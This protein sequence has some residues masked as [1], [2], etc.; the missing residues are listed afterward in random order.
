[1]NAPTLSP[2]TGQILNIAAYKFVELTDLDAMRSELKAVTDS[3]GLKGTILLSPE[4]INLFLAGK[5]P[6]VGRFLD[7]L[8]SWPQFADIETKDSYSDD[9]PFRRML[10][11]LKKEI[12]AFGVDGI[13]PA[14]RTSPKLPAKELKAWLDAGKKVRLLD[15][16][17][18]YEFDLGTFR[19]AEKL[20]LD[21]FRDFPEA[22]SQLPDDAKNEPLVM[23]CTGGIRCEKAGPLMEQAGF[24]EVYQLEG[25]ILKYFEECGDAHYDGDC[26]VFDNR[27]A[28]NANLEPTGDILCFACQAVL[29]GDDIANPHYKMGSHCPHCY[30]S[31]QLVR[32]RYLAERQ[33]AI[34]DLAQSQPGSSPYQNLR[35]IFVPRKS[36]GQPLIDFLCQRNP[37]IAREQWSAWIDAGEIKHVSSNWKHRS[38]ATADQIVR[39]GECFEQE[40]PGTIEPEIA[41]EIKL[42][43]EDDDLLVVS[44][45]A[46]LP[47]HPSGRFNRNTLTW[48]LGSVYGNDKLR[49]AHRLDANTSGVVLLCR[50]QRAAKLI[51]QQFVAGS[52]RK[53]YL[54]RVHGHPEWDSHNCEAKISIEPGPSGTRTIDEVGGWDARTEISVLRREDDGTTL[55]EVTPKTGRTNQIRIHLWHLGHSIVGDPLY[56]PDRATAGVA[57]DQVEQTAGTL[58]VSAQ[59]MCL[60]SLQL[61]IVHPTS[62]EAIEFVAPKPRWAE[63]EAVATK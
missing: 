30:Q 50:K 60:H 56:L 59:P 23:F 16:R 41:P 25:G 46:P 20:D 27:V 9:Q 52:V 12:I 49:A 38:P 42:V 14:K 51:Q 62:G 13:E 15:T 6:N 47:T 1:M 3:L 31:P 44:K 32:Q 17:N 11:R 58:D 39:D 24:K 34:L 26:F 4:G 22:I 2:K 53:K 43:Y 18:D 29:S 37:G 63:S 21:H 36:A 28:L 5:S 35:H 33:Q 10:V 54:A 48:I 57:A 45:P 61:A 8:R 40:E 7:S 55:L 19:G